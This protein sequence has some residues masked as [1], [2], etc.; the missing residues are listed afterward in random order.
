MSLFNREA[1]PENL[2]PGSYLDEEDDQKEIEA[3][4]AQQVHGFEGD[5]M[6][7]QTY[8]LIRVGSSTVEA[9]RTCSALFF[10][11][12]SLFPRRR[13]SRRETGSKHRKA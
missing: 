4:D 2:L 10:C 3:K 1:I 12:A 9:P 7:W 5:V 11:V 6:M 8:S 13:M